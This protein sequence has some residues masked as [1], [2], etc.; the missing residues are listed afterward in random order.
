MAA[1]NSQMRKRRKLE[2]GVLKTV[3]YFDHS[4]VSIYLTFNMNIEKRRQEAGMTR[5]KR[6]KKKGN[7]NAYTK[8]PTI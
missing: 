8:L 4:F 5:I 6:K 2:R 3:S 7:Q 1:D